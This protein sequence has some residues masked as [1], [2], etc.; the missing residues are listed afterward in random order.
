[1]SR[2]ASARAAI[3]SIAAWAMLA[4]VGCGPEVVRVDRTDGRKLEYLWSVPSEGRAAYY[5][6][7][8]DGAFTSSG[9]TLALDRG[10]SD[11][12][13]LSDDDVAEFVR[14]LEATSFRERS[15]ASCK[16]EPR[17]ELRVRV[18][19]STHAFEVCGAD[20]SLEALRT[21]C[22]AIALRKYRDV[23]DAQPEAGSRRR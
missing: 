2:V 3:V 23:I 11:R 12:T 7:A 22:A 20:A 9:G 14:L 5:V 8:T 4:S 10:T 19:G 21:W 1:M 18:G 13:T 6:V 15:D 16:G 17:H